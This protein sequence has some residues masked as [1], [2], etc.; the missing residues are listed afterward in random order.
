MTFCVVMRF[1][2]ATKEAVLSFRDMNQSM[3]VKVLDIL[4]LSL[5]FSRVLGQI[6]S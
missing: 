1:L 4:S 3:P 5:E 2:L 6:V